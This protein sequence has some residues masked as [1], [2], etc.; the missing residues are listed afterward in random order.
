MIPV[1]K[2]NEELKAFLNEYVSMCARHG[3]FISGAN[4][5]LGEMRDFIGGYSVSRRPGGDLFN[6]YLHGKRPLGRGFVTSDE[7]PEGLGFPQSLR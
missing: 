1:R 2:S 7:L 5:H 3:I 6:E 4:L